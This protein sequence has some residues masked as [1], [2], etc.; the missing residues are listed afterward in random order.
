MKRIPVTA[1]GVILGFAASAFGQTPAQT[2]PYTQLYVF[3]D[4]YFGYW[5]GLR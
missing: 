5:G 2:R 1:L 3:G 4:S